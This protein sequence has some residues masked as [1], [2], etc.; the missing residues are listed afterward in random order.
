MTW[1]GSGLLQKMNPYLKLH[2]VVLWWV[3]EE[4]TRAQPAWPGDGSEAST[5]T[6]G[7]P[8]NEMR[9]SSTR[10]GR[11]GILAIS[12]QTVVKQQQVLRLCL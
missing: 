9:N 5:S 11:F 8:H 3:G 2:A 6:G 10:L 7:V 4:G 1:Y 12:L